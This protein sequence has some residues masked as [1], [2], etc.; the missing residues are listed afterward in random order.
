MKTDKKE[1]PKG[2][3]CQCGEVEEYGPY[4]AAHWREVLIFTC[5]KCGT[6]Y[7]ILKGKA[8]KHARSR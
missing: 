6:K 1:M 8:K 2:F 3:T 5:P 7:D 4:V